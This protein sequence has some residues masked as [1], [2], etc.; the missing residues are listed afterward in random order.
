LGTDHSHSHGEYHRFELV[1]RVKELARFITQCEQ[2]DF[3][4]EDLD[5][6]RGVL[7]E[8]R[9]ATG[10][11]GLSQASTHSASQ[12]EVSSGGMTST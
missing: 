6:L 2:G 1:R 11:H 7:Y 9:L 5:A 3:M 10:T 4:L 8:L 12:S